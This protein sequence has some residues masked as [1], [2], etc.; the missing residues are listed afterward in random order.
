[1][2]IK[3]G[4]RT[5]DIVS[6]QWNSTSQK[7]YELIKALLDGGYGKGA[8]GDFWIHLAEG[9]WNSLVLSRTVGERLFGVFFASAQLLLQRQQVITFLQLKVGSSREEGGGC[10]K[11][12]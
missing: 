4:L 2:C 6:F 10:W 5:E 12:A 9:G 7:Q 8:A 11:L 3:Q 1:M